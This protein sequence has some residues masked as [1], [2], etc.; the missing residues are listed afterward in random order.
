MRTHSKSS[1]TIPEELQP[2]WT[3]QNGY[4]AAETKQFRQMYGPASGVTADD[5]G[6]YAVSRFSEIAN[7]AI[8]HRIG[9][10]AELASEH[11]SEIGQV[12]A[13]TILGTMTLEEMMNDPRSRMKA[14]AVIHDGKIVFE[15]Y[16]G[17]RD[18]DNHLWASATKIIIGTLMYIAE[19]EGLVDLQSPLT[20]YLPELESTDW[21]GVKVEDVLHQRS[22]L[23]ISES[24]LGSAPDHPVTLLY[25]IMGG[26]TSLPP[27]TSLIEAV[28]VSKKHLEPGERYEYASLNTFVCGLILES[29]YTMPIE[30]LITERIWRKSGMEGDAVLGL[31]ASGEPMSHGAFAARLRDLA[32]FGMLFTPSWK[33]IAEDQII[34]DGYFEKVLEA[35]NPEIYGDDYMSERLIHDFNESGFGASYQWD[36]VFAD[37]DMYKSGRTG[38]CLYVSPQTNTVIVWFSSAYQAEVWVHAYAR[39]IVKQIFR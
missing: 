21:E 27:G 14:I 33:V 36:A 39:E 2:V 7:T 31:S 8:V 13:T 6:S 12:P 4:S 1:Y 11:L 10:V 16:I 19:E 28:K 30:D 25:A 20:T 15:K 18:W 17:I 23:D 32:R 38:Q 24:R 35:A 5:V 9:Q 29:V 3:W 34:S 37:G 22:G 26:D